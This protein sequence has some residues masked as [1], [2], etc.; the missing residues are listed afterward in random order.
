MKVITKKTIPACVGDG[1]V[2]KK[3][4]RLK[5][6]DTH[7]QQVSDLFCFDAR[8]LSDALSSGRSIDY[9]DSVFLSTGNILYSNHSNEMVK[10]VEDS[11]WRHDFLLPPCSQRMF[12]IVNKNSAPHP[13]C[14]E[15]LATA[16]DGYGIITDLISTSF[17]IFM[18]VSVTSDGK[19]KILPPLSN[20]GDYIIFEAMRDIIVGLTA[21]AHEETNNGKCKSIDY[22]IITEH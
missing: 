9:N 16:L 6:I 22:E 11:C 5:V 21:C 18:N 13:S 10:I 15:N 17:N 7:G 4:Q 1:F 14:H 2:L 20:P 12:E 8:N 19:I 3:G